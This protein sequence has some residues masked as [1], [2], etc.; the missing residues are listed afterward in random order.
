MRDIN[1]II[2]HCTATYPD[3]DVSVALIDKWHKKRGWKGI[4]YH[5]LLTQDGM[6][7]IGRPVADQGA[8]VKNHNAD[9]IGI[10]YAG[11]LNHDGQ[12]ADTMTIHQDVSFLQ[13]VRSLRL[14]FGAL[15]LHGH[16]EFS[17]KPC[18]SFSVQEKYSFIL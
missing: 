10:A 3:Q 13:L 14:V 15:T 8:H 1:R 5:Y 17:D 16:N 4:G 7:H 2:L 9:S 11:G 18:P 6:V 12:P